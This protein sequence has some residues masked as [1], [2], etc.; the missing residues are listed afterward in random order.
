M[1]QLAIVESNLVIMHGLVRIFEMAPAMDVGV[2]SQS[3]L[4][5]L[6]RLEKVD[7]DVVLA[8]LKSVDIDAMGLISRMQKKHPTV[9]VIVNGDIHPGPLVQP[10]LRSGACTY[11]MKHNTAPDRIIEILR[12][13]HSTGFSF[14][15]VVTP[16]VLRKT[17]NVDDEAIMPDLSDREKEILCLLCKGQTKDA[18]AEH[19]HISVATIKYHMVSLFEKCE[20][21][22]ALELVVKALNAH[23]I[24]RVRAEG[25]FRAIAS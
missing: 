24:E 15:Q 16:D 7:V 2:F 13:V 3:G 21:V 4:E 1:L 11:F 9:K 19:L 12:E 23:W 25:I 8:D 14:T 6:D 10:L 20:V 22:S 5:V 18:M 17:W